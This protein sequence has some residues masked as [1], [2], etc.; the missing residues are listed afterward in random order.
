M[1][2]PSPILSIGDL[3]ADIIVSIPTLPA[4]AGQHQIADEIQLEPGGNANF[5]IA[6]ARLGYPMAALGVL[7][8]DEWGHRVA[9]LVRAEG[10]DL[11]AV[12]HSGTT[13]TVIVLVSQANDHVFLGKNG[14][15]SKIELGQVEIELVKQAKAIFFTGY[16]L[17]ET[18]LVDIILTTL[19][20][21]KQAKIPIYFDPSPQMAQVPTGLRQQILPL[22]NTIFTTQEEIPLLV[23]NGSVANLMTQGPQTV[24]VKKGAAGCT[25]YNSDGQFTVLGYAVPVVDTEAAG[26]SFNAAFMVA[27]QWGWPL[28]ECAT[29]A[30]AV[31]A[32]KVQKLGGGRQVPTLTEIRAILEQFETDIDV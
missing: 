15:G 25:V 30:N 16:A 26:D 22:I 5:L 3:V 6:G 17:A 4:E 18:G 11:S 1:L 12:Q 14:Y 9:A 29:L 7:G 19:Q 28:K 24:V 20:E 27:Q 32:A 10:V 31:G 8:K 2:N 23:D 21:A 13:T